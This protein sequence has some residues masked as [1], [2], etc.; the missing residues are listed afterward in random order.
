MRQVVVEQLVVAHA[1]RCLT[2][3]Y[4]LRRRDDSGAGT[5]SG[6][7]D[8]TNMRLGSQSESPD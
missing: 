1:V 6:G 4:L 5:G 8:V 2:T 3:G 7:Q